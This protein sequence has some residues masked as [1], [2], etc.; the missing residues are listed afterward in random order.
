MG[1]TM[2]LENLSVLLLLVI[3]ISGCGGGGGAS[4]TATNLRSTAQLVETAVPA[5]IDL[6]TFPEVNLTGQDFAA[7]VAQAPQ[8]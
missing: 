8:A 2:R 1:S 7:Y 4:N 5:A 3:I 6:T